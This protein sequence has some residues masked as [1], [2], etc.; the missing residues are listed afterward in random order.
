MNKT[1]F[2]IFIWCIGLMLNGLGSIDISFLNGLLGTS[3]KA[4]GIIL[5]LEILARIGAFFIA[6]KIYDTKEQAN[7]RIREILKN[8]NPK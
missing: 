8:Q 4:Q 1:D 7:E 3:L 5:L 2:L 6:Y